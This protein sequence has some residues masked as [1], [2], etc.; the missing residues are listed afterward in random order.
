M[1]KPLGRYFQVWSPYYQAVQYNQ[2]TPIHVSSRWQV[3]SEKVK[4]R[5]FLPHCF[6]G[7]LKINLTV[8]DVINCLN[9]NL[10]TYFVWY[11]EK[12]KK[13]GIETLFIDRVLK[14]EQFYGKIIH[15]MWLTS[16]N[17]IW[18]KNKNLIKNSGHKFKDEVEKNHCSKNDYS[19]LL[20]LIFSKK[21]LKCQAT[22]L[23]LEYHVSNKE[24]YSEE[25][26]HQMFMMF[27]PFPF[28]SNWSGNANAKN[29]LIKAICILQWAKLENTYFIWKDSGTTIK[30][31]LQAK[32]EYIR[33]HI[34][35]HFY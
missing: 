8:Y 20:P 11:L 22:S 13:Y 12:E 9:K 14:K 21:K 31:N 6:R 3:G 1:E 23:V 4:K 2:K 34:P 19:K 28:A 18:W 5:V 30:V 24:K 7:W 27:F 25:F 15:K 29:T 16:E 35:L 17:I 32:K 26:V 33:P 10:I